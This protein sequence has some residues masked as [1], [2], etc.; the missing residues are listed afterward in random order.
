MN[1]SA[2]TNLQTLKPKMPSE[3]HGPSSRNATS[4]TLDCS[5]P[6]FF[7]KNS[8]HFKTKCPRN[9]KAPAL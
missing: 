5:P 9:F 2:P 4:K 3:I 6:Q 8:I 1:D 7:P